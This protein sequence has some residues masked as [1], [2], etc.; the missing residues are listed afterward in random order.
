MLRAL[1][2]V[3]GADREDVA[4]SAGGA[5][6]ARQLAAE[7]FRRPRVIRLQGSAP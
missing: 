2:L 3:S 5:D 4:L 6:P 7:V 1:V